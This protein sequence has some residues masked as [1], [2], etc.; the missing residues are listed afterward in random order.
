MSPR[1]SDLLRFPEGTRLRVEVMLQP[2]LRE[3]VGYA[4]A[5]TARWLD[6]LDGATLKL[7]Q[8]SDE[9]CHLRS[10]TVAGT[11]QLLALRVVPGGTY[12]LRGRV[13]DPGGLRT[14]E[15]NDVALQTGGACDAYLAQQSGGA[16]RQLARLRYE[17]HGGP[18]DVAI[19]SAAL[20]VRL[21]PAV[22]ALLPDPIELVRLTLAKGGDA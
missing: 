20:A 11:A 6:S 13:D 21:P 17:A 22:R 2:S 9:A 16:L 1:W 15:L 8:L 4:S 19:F 10:D 3:A 12:L 14:F 5:N 7:E 18:A